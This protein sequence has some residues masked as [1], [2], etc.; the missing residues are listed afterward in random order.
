VGSAAN[1][2]GVYEE[3]SIYVNFNF[4]TTGTLTANTGDITTATTIG[5]NAP[6]TVTSVSGSNIGVPFGIVNLT[7]PTPVT[8]GSTFLKS[9]MTPIGQFTETLTVTFTN[10]I[11]PPT[12]GNTLVVDAT[13]TISFD[14]EETGPT[15]FSPTGVFYAAMYTQPAPGG[16]ITAT[17]TDTTTPLPAALPLFATGIGALGLLGWRRKRKAQAVA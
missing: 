8:L 10:A 2:N 4:G 11:D 12:T 15:G 3:N 17:F 13:G 1:A 16:V 7:N 5:S 14:G 6:F 9:F